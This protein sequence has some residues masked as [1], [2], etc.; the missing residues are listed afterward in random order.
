VDRQPLPKESTDYGKQSN[1]DQKRMLFQDF[2]DSRLVRPKDV[3]PNG[4]LVLRFGRQRLPMFSADALDG[5][6]D[7]GR[8]RI[9]SR[10]VD[11]VTAG[12]LDGRGVRSLGHEPLCIW[13]DHSILGRH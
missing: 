3:R 1:S 5:R 6:L 12:G 10:D 7:E 4:R 8:H 11:G 2:G 13:G 9:G